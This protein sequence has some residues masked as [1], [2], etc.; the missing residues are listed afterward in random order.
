LERK[1]TGDDGTFGV[2]TVGDRSWFTGE[3]PWRDIDR[4]GISDND[5]SCIPAGRYQCKMT[6]SPRFKTQTYEVLGVRGRHSIRIHPANYMGD[7]KKGKR[8]QL[9]GCIALG[10]KLGIMDG[11]GAVLVSR[12]AVREFE[13]ALN[14]EPFTLE[15]IGC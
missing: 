5:F 3:L 10:K 6:F 8:C 13:T 9:H 2:I 1:R 11:Q 12:P 7:S 4:D 14:K 15:V